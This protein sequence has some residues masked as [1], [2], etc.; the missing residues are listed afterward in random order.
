MVSI[1]SWTARRGMDAAAHRHQAW[2]ITFYRTGRIDS[3]VDGRRHRVI[4]GTVLVLPPNAA[5]TEMARTAYSNFYL[6]V[7]API[8]Q[9]WPSVCCGPAALEIG[10][11]LSA[12]VREESSPDCWSR[13]CTQ[14][15]LI[16]V[17]TALRRALTTT[18]QPR[19]DH[20]VRQ[21]EEIFE[22]RY[23]GPLTVTGI[24]A[25]LG[26]SASS[27]R[28]YFAVAGRPAPSTVLRQVRLRHAVNLLATSDLTLAAIAARCGYYSASHLSREVK[29]GTGQTPGTLRNGAVR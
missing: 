13:S 20:V 2:K 28:S 24:T 9:P 14:A 21:V 7:D 10:A 3:I 4:P 19:A 26:I 11:H 18:G 17:D 22:R 8:D 15:L 16:L 5:H 12:M 25:E 27:L 6:L 29:S 23:A 1:G